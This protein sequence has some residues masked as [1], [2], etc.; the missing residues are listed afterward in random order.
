MPSACSYATARHIA[1]TFDCRF[2]ACVRT[3]AARLGATP[4]GWKLR[5]DGAYLAVDDRSSKCTRVRS[6][7]SSLDTHRKRFLLPLGFDFA[8]H[9]Q[10]LRPSSS[11][12]PQQSPASFRIAVKDLEDP[13]VR[14]RWLA[15]SRSS[16]GVFIQER[17]VGQMDFFFGYRILPVKKPVV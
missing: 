9:R 14:C 11:R 13:A 16:N 4:R 5:T 10:T 1:R 17:S 15:V 12:D 3:L 2:R 8:Q 7:R 6:G